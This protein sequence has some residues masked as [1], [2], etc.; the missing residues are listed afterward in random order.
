MANPSSRPGTEPLEREIELLVRARYPILYLVSWEEERV[1]GIA[2]RI[3]SKLGKRLY[4]WTITR[5]FQAGGSAGSPG[6]RPLD[7]LGF[8]ARSSENAIFA[9]EDFHPFL[10]DPLVVRSLRDLVGDLHRSRKTLV[11]LSPLLKM[12]PELEKD[13]TV[14]DVPL[15][16]EGEL[17]TILEEILSSVRGLPQVKLSEDPMLKEQVVK[18]ALGLTANEAE[19]I[20]SKAIVEGGGFD[21]GDLALILDEKKQIIRKG[22][23]LEYFEHEEGLGEVGGLDELKTWVRSRSAAFT[24][25]ARRFG[26]PEP[27][28]LLLLGV[29]GC[30]KSL[31]AKAVAAQWKLPLLRLDVGAVFNPYV[32]SSESNMRKAIKLAE[33]IS[34]CVLWLDELEK[35]FAGMAAGRGGSGDSGTSMRVFATFLTWLQEKR[36]PVFV[37]ATANSIEDLPPELLRRGRF[38]EIFFLD[39]PGR[40]ARDAIFAIHFRRRGRDPGR[41]DLASLASRSEGMSGAEIEQ[42]IVSALYRAFERGTELRTADV[43]ASLAETVPLSMTMREPIEALREWAKQRARPA[44][45]PDPE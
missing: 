3:A 4:T 1:E 42:A 25:R 21:E 43:V 40:Q 16:G 8:V 19:N 13:V 36:K 32:G 28:G 14:I 20:F 45:S 33:S 27:K 12:P 23:L 18:A 31:T 35:G 11:L 7:A 5:G 22:E 9:L 41:F 17:M 6:Q 24:E 39:L 38:D 10:D 2:G 30:G 44:E 29:Q 34:P 37:V 26:L 15:P